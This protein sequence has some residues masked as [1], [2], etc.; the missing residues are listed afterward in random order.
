MEGKREEKEKA[1]AQ[2]SNVSGYCRHVF[3]SLFPLPL[4]R[5]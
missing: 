5:G 4:L 1:D 2:N 3:S